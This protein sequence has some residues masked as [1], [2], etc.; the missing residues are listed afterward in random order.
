MRDTAL[1]TLPQY[2]NRQSSS[3][4]STPSLHNGKP[5]SATLRASSPDKRL[6]D[7]SPKSSHTP[8][9]NG[10][11]T[12]PKAPSVTGCRYETGMAQAYRRIPYSIGTDELERPKAMPKKFLNPHEEAKLSGDMRELYDRLLP[13]RE[14]DQ[15]RA[16]FVKK[17]HRILNERWPGNDIQVHVFGSSGNKLCTNDS[18]GERRW[19][20]LLEAWL[21][22]MEV[23]ICVTTP[24]RLFERMCTLA[25]LLAERM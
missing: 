10:T 25:A 3:V 18:D 7:G 5:S 4:P 15:R 19:F 11:R 17:L 1:Q 21:T 9:E 6:R 24:S 23:D 20:L 22:I 13:S 2:N 8:M 14:S 16:N 12:R